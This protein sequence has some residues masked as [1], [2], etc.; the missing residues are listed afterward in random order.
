MRGRRRLWAECTRAPRRHAP[1]AGAAERAPRLPVRQLSSAVDD[2][3]CGGVRG[4]AAHG[5]RHARRA[6]GGCG[7]RRVDRRA[8]RAGRAHVPAHAADALPPADL[9]GP[10]HARRAAV[11]CVSRGAARALGGP[12][13][14]P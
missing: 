13:R 10:R 5:Q 2:A 14:K 7:V 12:A 4:R 1:P 8:A 11:V 9:R 6:A 3:G